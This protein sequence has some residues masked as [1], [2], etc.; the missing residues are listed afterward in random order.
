MNLILHQF[1]TDAL[2]FRWR[3]LML[4]MAFAAEI[5]LAAARF[6]PARGASLADGLIMMWQ[7]AAAVFL[8]AALVQAD[9]LVGTTA[10]WLTRPLRRPHLFW[11]KSLFI[12]TFLLLPKLAAQSVG[13][14]LRGYSGH[15]ILCAAAESLLY[16]VSAVL[17]VAV[18]ASLTSSLT[19]FFL[20][21]GIG[22]G[23]MF[24]W[25]VV[26]EMLKKAGIIKNAGANWNETGSF[27]ASQLIVAFVFLASCLA[28]AWMAQAR[29]RRWR[30]AL[31][32]LAVGV[33]AFPILNTRWRVNFL[34]PRLTESTPLTLE[35]VSTNAPGPRHG[36]QIF[37]EIFA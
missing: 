2:H 1:K 34:K 36:Q 25:L 8:V 16:S 35:F 9:S 23:G 14:S 6:F 12:V 5:V 10:A 24:A 37:T 33:M 11:A 19:R 20:A 29:F 17:V 22:I 32:L 28:L 3:I 26:V 18:L 30:V 31:V 7:I 13:W 15:L 21:V 27:N 4:W